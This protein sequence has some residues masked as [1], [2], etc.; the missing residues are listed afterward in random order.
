MR[1]HFVLRASDGRLVTN[2]THQ[3]A[4][5]TKNPALGYA[6]DTFEKAEFERE[7]YQAILGTKLCVEEQGPTSFL[8]R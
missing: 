4:S 5:L 7:A 8:R 2:D 6:W 3:G 1:S